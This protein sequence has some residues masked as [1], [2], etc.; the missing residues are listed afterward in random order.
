MSL[1]ASRN[2]LHLLLLIVGVVFVGTALAYAIIPVLEQK[3]TDAG[4]PPPPSEFR[5]ML[6]TDGW[7]WLLFEAAILLVLGLAS[8]IYDHLRGLQKA[9]KANT[10]P[11]EQ[12]PGPSP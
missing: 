12:P 6:R 8:I 11:P 9:P 7:R 1:P 2:P 5:D 3:A 4:E 10:I